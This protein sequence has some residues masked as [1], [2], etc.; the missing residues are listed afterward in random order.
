MKPD[1]PV[2]AARS[3]SALMAKRV[4]EFFEDIFQSSCMK[5]RIVCTRIPDGCRRIGPQRLIQVKTPWDF[6]ITYGGKSAFIDTKTHDD[7]CFRHSFIEKHQVE[8]M[9]KHVFQGG[10]GGYVIWL[11]E[12]DS[13]FFMPAAALFRHMGE[14]G[15][16]TDS[17]PNAIKLGP[18]LGFNP[19]G[20]LKGY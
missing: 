9:V 12:I 3:R 17:H 15:S 4:G 18:H 20:I 8:E 10:I 11:R 1:K 2:L 6:V 13:V 14:R 19:I 7:K 16:F 5:N